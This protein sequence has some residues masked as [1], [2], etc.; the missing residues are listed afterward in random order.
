MVFKEPDQ[1]TYSFLK[2]MEACLQEQFDHVKPEVYS[3]G[4]V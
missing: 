2:T 4:Q 3:M 1:E